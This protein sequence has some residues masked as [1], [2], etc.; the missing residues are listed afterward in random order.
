[1]R[2]HPRW[3]GHN[4]E[5]WKND[6]HWRREW[7]IASIFLPWKPHKQ[8]EKA[9]K[10][11]TP[12]DEPPSSESA[13]YATGKERRN[14]SRKNKEDG[15]NGNDTQLW[16]CLGMKI[17]SDDVKNTAFEP[18]MLG[19]WIK[20]NWT[21]SSRGG[22]SEHQ[23]FSHQWTKTDGNRHLIQMTTVV[24]TVGKNALEELE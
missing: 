2:G 24:V 8:Y 5:F 1:M 12:G 18:G 20:V 23:H 21:W 3:T 7:Q 19:P 11:M 17:K 22:K 14:S 15:P 16:I 13:Q 6:F 9:K 4:G 10:D